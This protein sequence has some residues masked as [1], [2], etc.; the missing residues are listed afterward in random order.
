[1]PELDEVKSYY[2]LNVKNKV[3]AYINRNLR[4]E[5]AFNTLVRYWPLNV[6]TVLEVGSGA[7]DN[8][9]R[10]RKKWSDISIIGLDISPKSV[11]IANRLFGDGENITFIQ[12]LLNKNL[13]TTKF[14]VIVLFDVYE[15]I[16]ND[17]K[18][19]FNEQLAALLNEGGT[20]FLTFPTPRHLSFYKKYRPEA[21]QLV[22]EDIDIHILSKLALD[23][24]TELIYYSDV[25]V[26]KQG[27]FAHA[28]LRKRDKI[29][30]SYPAKRSF[31]T[32]ALDKIS[33]L[34]YT[35]FIKPYR[36]WYTSSKMKGL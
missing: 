35:F 15:H 21:L 34:P 30:D 24:D 13:F 16:A 19:F 20:L 2:D 11:E 33:L 3:G 14:D 12:G 7:G 6:K 26:W 36:I 17:D 4:L 8:A 29:W 9:A 23:T 25:N 27:D 31:I 28:V 5:I 32:K 1:M 10:I 18:P 22:D